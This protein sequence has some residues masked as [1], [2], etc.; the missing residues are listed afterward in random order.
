MNPASTR[1]LAFY[2]GSRVR[3]GF[4]FQGWGLRL[5]ASGSATSAATLRSRRVCASLC[6]KGPRVQGF[7]KMLLYRFYIVL[8][9]KGFRGSSADHERLLRGVLGFG[10]KL[11]VLGFGTAWL[12]VL[13]LAGENQKLL[14]ETSEPNSAK[15]LSTCDEPP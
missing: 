15:L 8:G 11:Q 14:M 5:R 13:E 6:K 4:R 3:L 7:W 1:I 10:F 2:F 12:G 9:Y